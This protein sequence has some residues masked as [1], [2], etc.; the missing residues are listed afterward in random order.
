MQICFPFRVTDSVFLF[1]TSSGGD[2]ASLDH[3]DGVNIW[4]SLSNGAPSPRTEILYNIDPVDRNLAIRIGRYKLLFGT[5]PNFGLLN[6][7][8]LYDTKDV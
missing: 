8:T 7:T 2:I 5:F 3:L 1:H 6:Y 4:S